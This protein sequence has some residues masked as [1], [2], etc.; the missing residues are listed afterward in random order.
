MR[1]LAMQLWSDDGGALLSSEFL[2]L[3]STLVIGTAAGLSNVRSAVNVEMSEFA[4]ALM[5]LN[6]GYI[7]QGQF[8]CGAITGGSQAIDTPGLVAPVGQ[9]PVAPAFPSLINEFPQNAV[10]P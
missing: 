2:F 9:L 5:A 4:N 6:Q 1:K 10:F 3:A 7:I 8:G